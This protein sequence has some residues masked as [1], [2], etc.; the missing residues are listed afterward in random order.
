MSEFSNTKFSGENYANGRPNYPPQLYD[1]LKAIYLQNNNATSI[2]EPILIDL[3]CGPG[4]AT[5]QLQ[6]ADFLNNPSGKYIGIDPSLKMIEA[7][8]KQLSNSKESNIEFKIGSELDFGKD[9]VDNSNVAVITA[10]QCCHWFDFP[11]FLANAY[12]ILS[13]SKGS[14]FMYG[15]INTR[16]LEYPE[17]DGIIDDLDKGFETGFGAYWDQPG[18]KYLSD[19]LTDDF[20]MKTLEQSDF[21]N[22]SVSRYINKSDRNPLVL[23][24]NDEITDKP[25]YYLHK[26]ATIKHFREYVTTWSAYNRCK[27]EKGD[28]FAD[29]LI[30]DCFNKIFK[31]IPGLNYDSEVNLVW[32]TYVISANC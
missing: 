13:K 27:R 19:L 25:H 5:F 16:I 15:Y 17:L 32:S 26:R 2:K 30:D 21:K 23:L 31:T 29:K 14:L 24:N 22:V 8:E 3:G 9:F 6:A 4:T 12:K 11:A 1:K 7:A 18:R 10:V 28:E 20:F